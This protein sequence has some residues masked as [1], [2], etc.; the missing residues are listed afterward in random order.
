LYCEFLVQLSNNWPSFSFRPDDKGFETL[1]N[2]IVDDIKR[3]YGRIS[4]TSSNLGLTLSELSLESLDNET[5]TQNGI[6]VEKKNISLVTLCVQVS[7]GFVLYSNQNSKPFIRWLKEMTANMAFVLELYFHQCLAFDRIDLVLVALMDK[8]E[9][10]S[11]TVFCDTLT[12]DGHML[13][14][15]QEILVKG[16][17]ERVRIRCQA[18]PQCDSDQHIQKI[19]TQLIDLR[20]N[21]WQKK[22]KAP[23]VPKVL[24]KETDAKN[25]N[26]NNNYASLVK[27]NLSNRSKKRLHVITNTDKKAQSV[28]KKAVKTKDTQ[29][30]WSAS[31]TNSSSEAL[32]AR[33]VSVPDANE[34]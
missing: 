19:L 27:T 15:K 24:V 1:C 8:N 14:S 9:E 32:S 4:T 21:A 26:T 30:V 25:T 23:E 11:W 34:D 33:L 16:Y 5:Q 22:R 3:K 10:W 29:S 12:R 18:K 13:E 20:E 7:L 17:F 6:V 31:N 2:Q 28:A